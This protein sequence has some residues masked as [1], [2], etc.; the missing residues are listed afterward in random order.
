MIVVT[1]ATGFIGTYLVDQLLSEGFEVLATGRS[2][3]GEAYFKKLGVPFIPLDVTDSANFKLLPQTNVEGVVHLAALLVERST[4]GTTAL[5]Y[6][7]TNTIGTLNILD[8]CRKVGCN[9]IV[10]TTSLNEARRSSQPIKEDDIKF[11]YS[12][13]HAAYVI[14]KL[15]AAEYIK[16]YSEEY[17]MKGIVVRSSIIHGLRYYSKSVDLHR[18]D[19]AFKTQF[20]IFIETA[21]RGEPLEIWGDCS[22]TAKVRDLIYI[23][24]EVGFIAACLK[25]KNASGRYNSATGKYL[26]LDEEIKTIIK[27]FSPTDHPSKITYAPHKPGP[28]WSI[29]FDVSKTRRGID[30]VPKY[31]TYEDALEDM[32]KDM[33]QNG[34]YQKIAE[35]SK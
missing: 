18:S 11:D 10:Y 32:K 17:G 7:K 31:K 30:W 26:T 28:E 13:N 22:P 9:K 14:S 34:H 1:G 27:V 3:A 19:W 29:V 35:A 5:D 15:T 23:K 16:H 25:N 8:Y 4:R 21:I 20:E 6:L 12:G 33:I 2:K 24:D